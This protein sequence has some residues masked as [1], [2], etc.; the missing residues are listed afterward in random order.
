MP[1]RARSQKAA[2]DAGDALATARNTMPPPPPDPMTL[3]TSSVGAGPM[4]PLQAV[5]V[6]GARVFTADAVAGVSK[7]EAVRVMQ[8]YESSLGNSGRQV[9]PAQPDA[10]TSRTYEVDGRGDDQPG[11]RLR[12][13]AVGWRQRWRGCAVVAGWSGVTQPGPGGMVGAGPGAVRSVLA[14]E[15]PRCP[16]WPPGAAMGA[17]GF[18]AA[19]AAGRA[20]RRKRTRPTRADCPT[21]TTG[22]SRWT[23]EPVP[24]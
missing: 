1:G 3:M 18:F 13:R 15:A 20:G 9:V 10:T 4:P 21:W 23:S 19:M 6:G 5:L 8:R 2:T 22:S 7:A 11:R 16:T 12:R 24:R 17:G 14:A